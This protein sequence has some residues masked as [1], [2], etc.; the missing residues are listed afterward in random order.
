MEYDFTKPAYR[1]GYKDGD[2]VSFNRSVQAP[3]EV[4]A[5]GG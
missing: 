2:S 4:K 5:I 3:A 1:Q